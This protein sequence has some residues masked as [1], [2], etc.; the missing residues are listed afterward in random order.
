VLNQAPFASLTQKPEYTMLGRTYALGY[1]PDLADILLQRPRRTVLNAEWPWAVFYPLRRSGKFAQ[2]PA[3]E[4]RVIL[5]EHGAIGM[6]FGAGDYAH[7]IRLACYGLDKNDND[8]V[9]GLLGKDLFW[10]L[11]HLRVMRVTADSRLGRRVQARGEFVIGTGRRRL[12]QAGVGFHPRV[13][14]ADGHAVRF[15]D[16]SSLDTHVI[17]WATGYR[18][19]YSWTNVPGV[20]RD[21][22]PVHQRGVTDVP[23]LYFIGLTWQQTRGS[24][25]LGFLEED[26]AHIANRIARYHASTPRASAGSAPLDSG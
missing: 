6:S 9:I 16:G 23:G 26:A 17:I 15:V 4:Q 12:K 5:A 22:R 3:E 20:V 10:W 7:D 24:A 2:L 18:S 25:L 19:D 13:V 11:T 21:G 8:F 14:D 1:E